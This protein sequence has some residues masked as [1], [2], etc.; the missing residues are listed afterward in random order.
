MA[1]RKRSFLEKVV[2]QWPGVLGL[3]LIA[4]GGFE[5]WVVHQGGRNTNSRAGLTFIV[6]GVVMMGYWAFANRN[7]DYNF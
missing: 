5:F 4:F 1:D 6:I 2:A 3:L 7:D